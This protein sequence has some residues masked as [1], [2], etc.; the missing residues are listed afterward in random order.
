MKN[1]LALLIF[2]GAAAAWYFYHQYSEAKTVNTGYEKT[3]ALHEQSVAA[4]KAELQSYAQL[5]ELQNQIKGKQAEIAAI[6]AKE[7]D[8]RKRLAAVGAEKQAVISRARQS[9]VGQT[10]PELVL[11]DGRKLQNVKVLKVEDS[12]LSLITPTG[13][14]KITAADLP[15][16]MRQKL[17]YAP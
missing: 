3:L 1:F 10:W 12:G 16:E 15:P 11:A 4:R 9:F 14:Q 8:V 6:A 13:V 17:H 2:V 7:A 5:L